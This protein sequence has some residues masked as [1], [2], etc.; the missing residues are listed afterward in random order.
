MNFFLKALFI[1]I[2]GLFFVFNFSL[3]QHSQHEV[4][5]SVN[6]LSVEDQIPPS[7]IKNFKA[8][9]GNKKILLSWENPKDADFSYVQIERGEK[10][11]IRFPGQGFLIYKDKGNSYLDKNLINGK[12]YYYT[13]WAYDKQGNFSS[14]SFVSA[15]PSVFPYLILTIILLGAVFSILLVK[16]FYLKK[17]K[18]RD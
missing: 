3:S 15:V 5:V 7:P 4:N 14:P 12:R 6:V 13:A 8:K 18:K 17:I 16:Y 2:V 9:P 1:F 10:E 11:F